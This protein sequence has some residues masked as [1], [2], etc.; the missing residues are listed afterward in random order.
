MVLYTIAI[1]FAGMAFLQGCHR[2][3]ANHMDNVKARGFS[4]TPAQRARINKALEAVE[5]VPCGFSWTDEG[6]KFHDRA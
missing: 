4:L 5:D 3:V 2:V 1:F 6:I